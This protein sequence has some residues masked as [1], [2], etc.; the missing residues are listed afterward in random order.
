MKTDKNFNLSKSV[1]RVLGS[2]KDKEARR[3]YKQIM[4]D[5]EASFERNKK[6]KSK[7]KTNDQSAV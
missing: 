3:Q 1:K 2:I 4:I 7:E 5:A 6:F